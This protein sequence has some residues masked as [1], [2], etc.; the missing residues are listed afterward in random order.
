MKKLF[1]LCLAASSISGCATIDKIHDKLADAALL[2]YQ[3]ASGKTVNVDFNVTPTAAW[4][5]TEV[6]TPLEKNWEWLKT[7]SQIQASSPENFFAEQAVDSA[8]EQKL[9]TNYISLSTPE[10]ET[11][12]G[13]NFGLMRKAIAT[14][15]RCGKINP[16]HIVGG[17]KASTTIIK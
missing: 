10:T 4:E 5:C 6:G 14:Y 17:E 13:L 12:N 1:F 16:D 2:K 3:L 8:N 15:Y 9:D 11:V 7:T